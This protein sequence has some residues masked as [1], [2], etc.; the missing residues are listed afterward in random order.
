MN[1]KKGPDAPSNQKQESQNM[2]LDLTKVDPSLPT[3]EALDAGVYKAAIEEM[4]YALSSKGNPMITW[5]FRVTEPGRPADGRLLFYHTVLNSE[6]G[7]GRLVRLL[8]RVSPDV[9]LKKVDVI[10]MCKEGKLIGF[11]CRV[12]VRIRRY[13][14]ERRNDVTDVMAPEE[15]DFMGEVTPE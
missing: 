7:L 1:D 12:K 3:F 11:P 4:S 10:T 8:T 2:V 13:E 9:D 15:G 5:Q 14:G 6:A